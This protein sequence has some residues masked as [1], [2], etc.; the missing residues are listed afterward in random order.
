MSF[1]NQ[2]HKSSPGLIAGCNPG[3][4]RIIAFQYYDGPEAGLAIYPLG[5]GVKFLSL[6]DSHS[7][8]FRAFELVTIDGN[9][10]PALYDD[11]H[12]III[13]KDC[14]CL[15]ELEKQVL[16]ASER[17]Y[18][19]GIGHGSMM[20]LAVTASSKEEIEYLRGLSHPHAFREVHRLL[21]NRRIIK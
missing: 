11:A 20:W 12:G 6:G 2:T 7:K 16:S 4:S 17:G 19:I 15:S 21:K 14:E 1:S 9:W 3:F 8:L 5:Q 13:S 10:Y 18:F